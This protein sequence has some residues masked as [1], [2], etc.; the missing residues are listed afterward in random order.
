[1]PGNNPIVD[2]IGLVL[3]QGSLMVPWFEDLTNV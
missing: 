1:L 2:G 3:T